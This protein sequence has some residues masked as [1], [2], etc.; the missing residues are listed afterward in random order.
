MTLIKIIFFYNSAQIIIYLKM[1]YQVLVIY[2]LAGLRVDNFK[3]RG[4]K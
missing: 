2:N 3:K 1:L 4:E